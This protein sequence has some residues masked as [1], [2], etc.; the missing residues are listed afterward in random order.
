MRQH[1]AKIVVGKR[2]IREHIIRGILIISTS[3]TVVSVSRVN[4]LISAFIYDARNVMP[5]DFAVTLIFVN[6]LNISAIGMR[7][8]FDLTNACWRCWTPLVKCGVGISISN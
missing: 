7:D 4:R 6:V 5:G 8:L 1:F 2:L 3:N